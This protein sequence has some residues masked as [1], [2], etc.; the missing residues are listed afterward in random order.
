MA[1]DE[2][3]WRR[4]T[5][6]LARAI[7]EEEADALIAKFLDEP[8]RR[9]DVAASEERLSARIS[10]VEQRLDQKITGVEQRLDQR[11]TGVEQRLD[12]KITG[13]EQRLDQKITGVE[14]RLDQK[15]DFRSAEL[16]ERIDSATNEVVAVVRG[17]LNSQLKSM[18]FGFVG[19][20][21]TIGAFIIGV[22]RFGA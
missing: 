11:I 18:L 21:A 14:Q 16:A 22:L 2:Q 9:D 17:E 5:Q 19:L 13:V 7:G 8:A 4:A 3:T 15:I 20:Q 6:A 1:I 10:D 12:Q